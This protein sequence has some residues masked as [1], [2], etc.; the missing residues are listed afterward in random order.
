MMDFPKTLAAA[1]RAK[2]AEWSLA[3]ALY[4]EVGPRGSTGRLQ[5]CAEYL[6]AYGI[7]YSVDY[8]SRLHQ[9]ARLFPND[10]ARPQWLTPGVAALD[11]GTPEVVEAAVAAKKERAKEQ[12]VE[13]EPPSKRE[14]RV[15][16]KV[17][18]RHRRASEGKQQMPERDKGRAKPRPTSELRHQANV[19]G[20]GNHAG[21]AARDGRSFVEQLAG[22]ELDDDDI[23]Y[24]LAEI[25]TV[26]TTWK[27]ARDAVRNPLAASVER[28]L[29]EQA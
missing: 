27:V 24:L 25:D 18:T 29:Q 14:L 7:D 12:G 8:L 19:L 21:H 13:Y 6:R 26:L 9:A 11:A 5:D 20:L 23:D 4:E 1:K 16:R 2:G 28:F 10:R 15:M 3:D 22:R 17:V